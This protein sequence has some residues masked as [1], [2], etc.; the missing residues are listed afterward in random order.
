MDSVARGWRVKLE[1]AE[2]TKQTFNA[3]SF[4]ERYMVA[5]F[6]YIG[7]GL[8]ALSL[9]NPLPFAWA[10]DEPQ[11]EPA[12]CTYIDSEGVEREGCPQGKEC[13]DGE[14]Y[15]PEEEFCCIELATNG[16]EAFVK[17]N[18]IPVGTPCCNGKGFDPATEGCC[19]GYSHYK[20]VRASVFSQIDSV[21]C[22]NG[23]LV[24]GKE[25]C[26]LWKTDGY[27]GYDPETEGCC[28]KAGVYNLNTHA[29]CLT[30]YNSSEIYNKS[31]HGCCAGGTFGMKVYNRSTHGCCGVVS[32]GFADVFEKSKCDCCTPSA[33]GNPP[34]KACDD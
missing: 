22:P 25:C 33:P 23:N 34:V 15:D 21:C 2:M 30:P 1:E 29:C 26:W 20:L 19:I 27:E 16:T 5:S 13:C 8:L 24:V 4:G 17:G 3:I 12:T 10:E 6:I 32:N 14:C 18:L 9:A 11:N 31:T 28:K 7:I